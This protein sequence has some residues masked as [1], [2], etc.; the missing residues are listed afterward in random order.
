VTDVRREQR[1]ARRRT[2]RLL[3]ERRLAKI[4]WTHP[5]Q[6]R[7]TG[8]ASAST[9]RGQPARSPL[10]QASISSTARIPTDS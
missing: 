1:A 9:V 6:T 10:A 2:L 7:R 8:G 5:H 4:K 3:A